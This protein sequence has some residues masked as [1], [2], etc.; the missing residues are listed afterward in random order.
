MSALFFLM[1]R[2][3]FS[4]SHTPSR[5]RSLIPILGIAFGVFCFV[6]VTSIMNGFAGNLRAYL[7][8]IQPHITISESNASK[9]TILSLESFLKEQSTIRHQEIIYEGD[10]LIRTKGGRVAVTKLRGFE[11]I[12]QTLIDY[13]INENIHRKIYLGRDLIKHLHVSLGESVNITPL[14]HLIEDV[15]SGFGPVEFTFDVGGFLKS[16]QFLHDRGIAVTRLDATS[17]VFFRED[18]QINR[19]VY[20]QEPLSSLSLSKKIKEKYP[21]IKVKTWFDDNAPLLKALRLEKLG[22][23]FMMAMMLLVGA[24]CM[25]TSLLMAIRKKRRELS[26]LICLGLQRRRLLILFSLYALLMSTV[27]FLIGTVM[28][29]GTL[30][31]I[32]LLSVPVLFQGS[33]LVFIALAAIFLTLITSQIALFSVTRLDPIKGLMSRY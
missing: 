21:T 12:P 13:E 9:E 18:V 32:P 1:K 25:M 19:L 17:S 23:S 10:I 26:I 33:D 16:G 22:M 24:L 29:L 15:E 2:Y 14:S 5:I 6:T 31:L 27:G 30:K 7:F 20:L 4:P 28:S 3:L 8:G 11:S